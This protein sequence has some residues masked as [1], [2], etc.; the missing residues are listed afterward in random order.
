MKSGVPQGFSKSSEK[1]E[2][3]SPL[4][5][6]IMADT[7][8]DCVELQLDKKEY[9]NHF[10]TSPQKYHFPINPYNDMFFV[11]LFVFFFFFFPLSLSHF[12]L[13]LFSSGYRSPSACLHPVS[14]LE[15]T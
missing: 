1:Q 3:S 5:L 8:S 9:D 11:C 6:F 14:L 13:S 4:K 15:N 7:V 12:T 10:K 2:N